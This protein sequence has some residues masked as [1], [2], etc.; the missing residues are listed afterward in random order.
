[1]DSLSAMNAS[2]DENLCVNCGV[3]EKV[4]PNNSV[5][6]M[7]RPQEWYQGWVDATRQTSSSGG[8]AAGLMESFIRNGGYVAACL[9]QNGEFVFDITNDVDYAKKFAGSKY[10]KSNPEGIY[11]KV[12]EKIRSGNKVLFIG[13]PCQVAAVKNYIRKCDNL[14]TVDLICHG[15]PS[16]QI[17][18]RFLHENNVDIQSISDL[19]F[20]NKSG[21]GLQ[22]GSKRVSFASESDLYTF[23]FLSSLDYTENCYSCRY[24]TLDRVSDITLG[25]S[26]GSELEVEE[27]K[28]GISLILCQ[29]EK[30]KELLNNTKI[31]LRD[32]DLNKAVEA[33]HQLSYPS[34]MPPER[35]IFFKSIDKGFDHAIS[36]CHPKMYYIRRLKYILY[37]A[38]IIRGQ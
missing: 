30:G 1:M 14:Y 11:K 25:D 22:P 7:K 15:S 31:E 2:I 12:S 6:K 35:K 4:C 10:V 18:N 13:L 34:K 36:R 16:P 33:N 28:K 19:K 27:Q 38:K 26:W 17:L 9:F 3:C 24:A 32:V 5:L 20:R 29:T 37:K 8:V 23:A 21:F